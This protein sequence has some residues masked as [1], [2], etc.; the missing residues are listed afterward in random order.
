VRVVVVTDSLADVV[1]E[2]MDGE[3]HP[4]EFQRVAD[5]L[6]SVNRQLGRGTLLVLRYELAIED[7]LDEGLPRSFTP[8][9]Y[10][11]KCAVLFEHVFERFGDNPSSSASA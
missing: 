2:A 9:I 5:L 7:A 11:A 10:Q 6:L 3:V 8:D 4:A 1:F